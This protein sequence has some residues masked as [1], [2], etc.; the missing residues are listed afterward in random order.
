MFGAM[1]FIYYINRSKATKVDSTYFQLLI[2]SKQRICLV[3]SGG[4]DLVT[5]R[6]Q[7]PTLSL[8]TTHVDMLFP[9]SMC[10]YNTQYILLK[11]GYTNHCN[12]KI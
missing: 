9:C 10:S 1:H 4:R 7:S 2:Y 3:A 5:F 8:Y 11:Y 6:S 12:E